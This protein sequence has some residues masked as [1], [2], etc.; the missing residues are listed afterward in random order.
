VL[1]ANDEIEN[2]G[3]KLMLDAHKA[4]KNDNFKTGIYFCYKILELN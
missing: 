3:R 4:S 1:I 2:Y